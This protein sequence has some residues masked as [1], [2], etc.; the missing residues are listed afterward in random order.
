MDRSITNYITQSFRDKV[1]DEYVLPYFEEKLRYAFRTE[2]IWSNATLIVWIIS[3]IIL[4]CGGVF[5]FAASSFPNLPMGFIAG[6]FIVIGTAFK[7]FTFLTTNLDKI[8]STEINDLLKNIGTDFKIIDESGLVESSLNN[9]G[10]EQKQNY[11]TD[12]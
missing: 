1:R 10:T 2:Q 11:S 6:I 9:S 5:A 12:V 7:D 4:S 3:T 8:K